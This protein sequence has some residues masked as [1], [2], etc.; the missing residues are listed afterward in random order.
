MTDGDQ[1]ANS[2]PSASTLLF[3]NERQ[4]RLLVG[5]VIDYALYMLDPDGR[6]S[7]WNA[8]GERIKGYAPDEI[9]GQHFSRFYPPEDVASGKPERLLEIARST[10]KYEEEGWRLRK[11]GS[12]FWADVLITTLYDESGNIRGFAKVTR[13]RCMSRLAEAFPGY[14]WE[15]NRGYGTEEHREAVLRLGRC[16]E[17]RETFLRK[18]L[19]LRGD[20]A[21]MD[22]LAAEG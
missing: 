22:F 19:A 18:L 20:P 10:G 5:G 4:F 2:T 17:H 6:V 11:D 7:T 8:G 14:G 9:I 1:P 21:Q 16:A 12:R 15:T 13:D 3:D